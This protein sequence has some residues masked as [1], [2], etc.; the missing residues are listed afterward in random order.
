MSLDVR[1]CQCCS[2]LWP[3]TV[4]SSEDFCLGEHRWIVLPLVESLGGETEV[5]MPHP[6][7]GWPEIRV[8]TVYMVRSDDP[9]VVEA[10]RVR[11]LAGSVGHRGAT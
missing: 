3:G 1:L 11:L 10:E 6:D 7:G 8:T 9:A 2:A 4:R 5:V